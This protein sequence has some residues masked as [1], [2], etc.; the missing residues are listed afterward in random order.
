MTKSSRYTRTM[1]DSD[2]V[3]IWH[4]SRDV[5]TLNAFTGTRGELLADEAAAG[6]G[7]G[8]V[9]AVAPQDLASET[10]LADGVEARDWLAVF[11]E[12]LELLVDGGSAFGC[13]ET[14]LGRAEQCPLRI[15]EGLEIAGSSF[16]VGLSDRLSK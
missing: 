15:V 5:L 3:V 2:P 7:P 1:T 4:R 10:G 12:C 9:Q 6:H 16:V 14:G 11:V 13:G 8:D